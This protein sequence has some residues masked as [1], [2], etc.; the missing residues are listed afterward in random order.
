MVSGKFEMV[1]SM[2]L[3]E[4]RAF[5]L[6]NRVKVILLECIPDCLGC[7]RIGKGIV[8]EMGSLYS[9]IKPPSGNLANK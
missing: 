7:D 1:Y 2:S 9:I 8:D 6:N 4:K 3:F 5:P